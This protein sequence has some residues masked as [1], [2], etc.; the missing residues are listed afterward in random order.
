LT[1]ISTEN[2]LP[3]LPSDVLLQ[4][5]ILL[6]SMHDGAPPYFVLAV[7]R[8]LNSVFVAQL[9]GPGGPT[10]G[11]APSPDLYFHIWRYL[12][13]TVCATAISLLPKVKQGIRVEIRVDLR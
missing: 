11:P 9:V 6:W 8:F 7:R 4:T 3:E 13:S 10:A 12:M 2:V 5:E 1:T